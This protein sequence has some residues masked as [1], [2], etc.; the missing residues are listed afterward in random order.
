MHE[1]GWDIDAIGT[2]HAVLT[3]VTGYILQANDAVGYF[4]M[5]IFLFLLA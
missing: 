2:G 1:D 5:K 4:F 3:V